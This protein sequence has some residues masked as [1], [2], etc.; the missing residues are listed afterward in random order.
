MC[1][2][3]IFMK[4]N[5]LFNVFF[6]LPGG[7]YHFKQSGSKWC[8]NY[9]L[10]ALFIIQEPSSILIKGLP[11]SHG[12]LV[13]EWNSVILFVLC[14]Y[15]YFTTANYLSSDDFHLVKGTVDWN[16]YGIHCNNWISHSYMNWYFVALNNNVHV[17]H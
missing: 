4:F 8:L 10:K 15:N 13:Y 12:I 6:H 17:D 7:V 2:I 3:S 1:D 5:S 9:Y 11:S 14:Q 16:K